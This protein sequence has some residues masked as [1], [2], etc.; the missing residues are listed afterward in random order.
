MPKLETTDGHEIYVSD[1][2]MPRARQ[3]EWSVSGP[4][5]YPRAT[6]RGRRVALHR[7]VMRPGRGKKVVFKGENKL[8]CRRSNLAVMDLG[9]RVPWHVT[10]RKSTTGYIGV[11]HSG[12]SFRSQI[13]VDGESVPLGFFDTDVEAA[14]AYDSAILYHFG[15]RSKR[16]FPE[17][18]VKPRSAFT[19]RDENRQR[20]KTSN[21]PGVTWDERRGKWLAQVWGEGR[22]HNCGRYDTEQAAYR[23]AR[24][25]RR[26]LGIE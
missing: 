4:S 19:I 22:N 10:G 5:G 26:E 2:D 18:A 21:Y 1:S 20:V 11:T 15:P 14:L 25:K 12:D 9:D 17:R 3:Y 7:F 13:K 24:R 6:V 8:D 16:N 23:A